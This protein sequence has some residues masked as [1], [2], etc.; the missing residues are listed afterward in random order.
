MKQKRRFGRKVLSLLLVLC[1]AVSL[2]PAV[3]VFAQEEDKA[4]EHTAESIAAEPADSDESL[5]KNASENDPGAD[6]LPL[7]GETSEETSGEEKPDPQESEQLTENTEETD[8]QN[9]EEAAP[10]GQSGEVNDTPD[11][12][13]T[14]ENGTEGEP[15]TPKVVDESG[16]FRVNVSFDGQDLSEDGP[17]VIQNT[18]SNNSSKIMQVQIVRDKTKDVDVNRQYVLCMKTSEVFYFNGL[19]EVSKI[20]GAED[21]AIVKNAAPV[22]NKS[23]GQNGALAGF[24]N[25]SGEIRIKINPSVEDITIPDIGISYNIAL[26]GYSG[27]SQNVPNPVE[28]KLVSIENNA[29]LENFTDADAAELHHVKVDTVSVSSGSLAGANWKSAMSTDSF[30]NAVLAQPIILGKDGHISYYFGTNGIESQVYKTLTIKVKCPYITVDGKQY[31]LGFS[32]SDTALKQNQQGNTKGYSMSKA[33]EY[34]AAE[35][36]ITYSFENIYIGGHTALLYTPNFTWPNDAEIKDRVLNKDERFVI[37]GV[38]MEVVEQTGY[39]GNPSTLKKTYEQAYDATFVPEQVDVQMSSSAKAGTDV[40]KRFIYKDLTRANG[41]DGAVGFFDVHNEGA[42]DSPL[43]NIKFEF[44]TQNNGAT[45]YITRVNLPAYGTQNGTDVRFVLSNGSDEQSGTLHYADNSSFS[46]YAAALRAKCGVNESYYIKSISY[47]TYL[48]KGTKYHYE[49]AHSKRNRVNDSGLFFGYLEGD[50]GATASATMTISSAEEGKTIT[51]DGK[52]S[53]CSDETSTVSDKDYI[54]MAINSANIG[55]ASSQSITA[56]S[57]VTLNFGGIVSTEEYPVP[58]TN[59]VNGYHILKNG[60]FYVCLPEGVSIAGA[61]QVSVQSNG[62]SVTPNKPERIAGPFD[63][64]GV[65]AYWWAIP[66]DGLNTTANSTVNVSINLATSEAMPGVVWNFSYA[67]A[68]RANGQRISWGAANTSTTVYNTITELTNSKNDAMIQL[69]SYLESKSEVNDLGIEV[70]NSNGNVKLNV[71]RAEAKLDVATELSADNSDSVNGQVAVPG[72][73]TKITYAVTVIGKEGGIAEDFNYYIPIVHTDSMLD[74]GALVNQKEI[75]LQLS[76][77]VSITSLDDT[78]ADA[79]LPFDV[80]YTTDQNLNSTTIQGDGI[81]WVSALEDYARVTA[82]KISTKQNAFIHEKDNYRFDVVMKYDNSKGDFDQQ[83]GSVAQWRSFGHYT[84][85]RNNQSTTNSYPSPSNSV[86]IKYVKD[87][88]GTPMTLM[89]DTAAAKNS[90]DAS[91]KLET[92]FVKDQNLSIKRVTVSSGTQL[93][94]DDPQNLIGADANS[95]FRISFNINNTNSAKTL[96]SVGAAWQISKN[97]SITLQA[98]AFFS[99]ALT[100]I[101]TERYVDIVLGNDDIDITCRIKLER[102]VAAATADGSGVT[103]G[104]RFQVPTVSTN[105]NISRDSAFTALY[106]IKNFVPGNYSSQLLKWQDSNGSTINFPAG[107]TITMMEVD[108][109]SQI[110]S[111]WYYKPSGSSVDLKNFTRMAGTETYS[112]DTAATVGTT[113]R[114]LFVVN[115]GQADAPAGNY[116]LVFDAA[117]KN[118]VTAFAPVA[119]DVGLGT[120]K[121][122][123]LNAVSAEAVQN[124]AADVSYTVTEASGND[125]YTEGRSLSLVLK[126]MVAAALPQDAQIQVGDQVYSCNGQNEIIIPIGTIATGNKNLILTSKMFPETKQTYSFE[127]FLYL[128]NSAKDLAPCNGT[129]VAQCNLQFTK[130][131]ENRPA[132]SVTG[133]RVADANTWV[134]GQAID[135]QMKNLEECDVTV[136]VY[137]G[138]SS[139]VPVTDL[140]SSVSGIF[141][142]NGGIGTYQKANTQTGK[143]ILNSTAK[144]GTYRLIFEVKKDG[145]LLLS[146]PYYVIVRQ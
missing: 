121:G 110:T 130:T 102:K 99:K 107:T 26:L 69:A 114:Y 144:P 125:S 115:F 30:A 87:L 88:T 14:A 103:V 32:E 24:S 81:T 86:K 129:P 68:I 46:C 10:S 41:N 51:A 21:V 80:Y 7:N 28:V 111:Y 18:W 122:Y 142:M 128:A 127:A 143:L 82:V 16:A 11:E 48:Q 53:I 55:G 54:G 15:V 67:I 112:Y 71:A 91:Q 36:T 108:E 47:Q 75:G 101:T 135:I 96:P 92:T 100:D 78:A 89:L 25:Y 3:P 73:D 98:Q 146:V 65:Q 106:V 84:Y 126:P 58:N 13:Q 132:L 124:P 35:H 61:E 137:S 17:N 118:G 9:E 33:A 74:S 66:V 23:A 59:Q 83:A 38:G 120:T 56:G 139:T 27:G 70:L 85:V 93:V 42:Q 45:Y 39:L 77:A 50:M 12:V 136:T 117:A 2:F 97:S 6:E 62:K 123:S 79:D 90:K 40:A 49:T 72:K 8:H 134:S 140:V 141:S 116:R 22:V 19:P 5:E 64:G 94:S 37:Q 29:E 104:E 95:K 63:V 52:A 76:A 1:F 119:L 20:T 60:I 113:L 4:A 31:Y 138:I 133:D 57:S 109:N 105:C 131:A 44:N 43:L 145:E 34:D